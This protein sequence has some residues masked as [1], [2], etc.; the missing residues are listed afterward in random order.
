M[1]NTEAKVSI[2]IQGPLLQLNQVSSEI[3]KKLSIGNEAS[4]V[5]G[6]GYKFSLNQT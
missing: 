5:H 6:L 2:H 4:Q 1:G 3:R